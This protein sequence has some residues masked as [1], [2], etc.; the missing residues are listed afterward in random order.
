MKK[1]I[2]LAVGAVLILSSCSKS[3][4]QLTNVPRMPSEQATVFAGPPVKL[5][6]LR[7]DVEAGSCLARKGTGS[8]NYIIGNVLAPEAVYINGAV[9]I[10]TATSKIEFVGCLS[11]DPPADATVIACPGSVVSPGLINAHDHITYD[12]ETPN[13]AFWGNTRYD[14][15]ADWRFGT[16]TKPKIPY[17]PGTTMQIPWTELRQVMAGTTSIAGSGGYKGLLRNL[18]RTKLQEW[19]DVPHTETVDYVTFPLGAGPTNVEVGG[20]TNYKYFYGWE[21]EFQDNLDF[22]PHVAEGINAYARNELLCLNA[23]GQDAKQLT[24]DQSTFIHSVASI[25]PDAVALK[26][27]GASVVWSPRSN[28]SLYGNTATIT[29]YKTLG[30]NIALSSDWT[31]SGSMNLLRE[32]QCALTLN[33]ANFN[34]AFT[35]FDL[36]QMVTS[37]AALALHMD[38]KIGSLRVGKYGDIAVFDT[39]SG[40]GYYDA[41]IGADTTTIKLVMR[42]GLPLYGDQDIMSVLDGSCE[43]LPVS[44]PAKAACLTRE[45]GINYQTLLSS[46]RGSY[47]LSFFKLDPYNEPTCVPSRPGEYLGYST[48]G[49]PDGDGILSINDNCPLVFNPIRPVDNG[50][51]ADYNGDG[52]GDACDASPL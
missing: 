38:E 40:W 15:R 36:W 12:Q 39:P 44:G 2:F 42:G 35:S 24:T 20:C 19:G 9:E 4:L 49:D 21:N 11:Q 10:S 1:S 7:S 8:K 50:R 13:P 47:P 32:L 33:A 31:P 16:P 51:Q 6:V 27:A 23:I 41:V 30:L 52:T 46:N 29:L 17:G 14:Y 5:C 28:I 25:V 26:N 18:D 34:N 45:L 3:D 37:N 22:L 48:P 43:A